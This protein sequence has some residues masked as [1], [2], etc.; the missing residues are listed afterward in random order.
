V[1][2]DGSPGLL[3][4]SPATGTI[5]V[6]IQCTTSAC[7]TPMHVVDVVNAATC[8]ASDVAGC[9]VVARA[10]VGT[11]PLAVAIDARTRTLYVVNGG[12]NS[13]SVMN[14]ALC[15]AHV[16]TGCRRPVATIRVGSFP[17]DAALNPV[18]RTLYVVS[19]SGRVFVIDAAECN[20]RTPR[21]CHRPVRS[22]RAAAGAQAVDVDVATDTVYTANSGN[23]GNGNTVSV[24]NGATCN[25]H[26]GTGCTR[27]PRSVTVGSGAWW[28]AVDQS[29]DTVYVANNNDGTVSVINGARCNAQTSSGCHRTPPV[30][31]TG[32]GPQFVAVDHQ[33][34][35]AFAVN[36]FDDTVSAINTSACRGT[37]TSGC[38]RPA[39]AQRAAPDQG[40]G[41]NAFPNA[42]A[43]IP[44]TRTAY[45]L[46]VGGRPVMS[47]TS[48]RR[49]N[50]TNTRGCRRPVPAASDGEYLITAD[51]ATNTLYAG[52]LSKPQIDVING[53]S[54]HVGALSACAPVAEIP[55]ADPDANVGAIDPTTHTLYAADS[56]S[57]KVYVIDTA[58]CN[59]KHT[60]GCAAA[61]PTA[62]IGP[63][64]NA[65]VVNPATHTLYVSYGA[66][67]D[68]VAVVN[69]AACNAINASGCGQVPAVV[70]VGQ[71][72]FVLAVSAMTDTVYGPNEGLSVNGNTMSV[73]NGATCNGTDHSGCGMLAAT[74]KVGAG[75]VGVAVDDRTH[76]VYVANNANGDSPGTVSVINGDTCNG[77][78]TAGCDQPFRVMPAGASPLLIAADTRTG[79]L[80]VSD[81]SS[82]AITILNGSRCNASITIGCSTRQPERAVGS[83]P[84]GVAVNQ[85]T[86]TIY[87]TNLFQ[88]GS[89]SILAGRPRS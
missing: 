89:L 56:Q 78:A 23:T 35:T 27:A 34:H 31:T 52:N 7:T 32:A 66:K 22:V 69:T 30:V 86:G 10:E 73:I 38:Q 17:V 13:V 12:S 59:A 42:L 55:V 24:I 33:L 62:T 15:N 19:P 51:P 82:A 47:V 14:G 9:R 71:G 67:T 85:T 83:Q 43:L 63:F 2:L 76:T 65:P 74:A 58:A 80:Y 1:V 16:H 40:P 88:A 4:A 41:Y 46:T 6:P 60:A 48:I 68:K 64:P 87:V 50:A 84:L 57:G 28:L 26:D 37:V 81:F 5:Y 8:N 70:R 45:V 3:A 36:F 18:T 39:P 54:C 61:L 21:G 72:T 11:S 75:P 25:G 20:A 44:R 49:C 77:T 79:I 29:T 53:A